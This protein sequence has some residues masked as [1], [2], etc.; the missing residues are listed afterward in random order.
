MALENISKPLAFL[1]ACLQCNVNLDDHPIAPNK[2]VP[3]TTFLD[4]IMDDS[5][6]RHWRLD[7]AACTFPGKGKIG[8]GNYPQV[9][10]E[11]EPPICDAEC[12]TTAIDLCNGPMAAADTTDPVRYKK[13]SVNDYCG[14]TW[15]L[16]KSEFNEFCYGPQ[17][18]VRT[19]M[20]R[21]STQLK[22]QINKKALENY[23][24]GADNYPNGT[25][26]LTGTQTVTVINNQGNIVPAG[27]AA[28]NA[29]YR[30][31]YYEGATKMIGGTTLG[32]YFDVQGLQG[33]G[34][35]LTGNT[36]PFVNRQFAYDSLLDAAVQDATGDT[37]A[38]Y[39]LVFP[40]GAF[41][42]YTWNANTGY[43]EESFEDFMKTTITIDGITYD[44]FVM[45]DKKC[46]EWTI[47]LGL[48]F[49]FLCWDEEDYCNNEGFKWLF[50]F[51]C[52]DFECDALSIC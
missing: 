16:N 37:T 4:M 38:S 1:N 39:G 19:E 32:T 33:G 30:K 9:Y 44:Y 43:R 10:I 6:M 40:E 13:L 50:K 34:Q 2:I 51:A 18:R 17:E 7:T 48:H 20:R 29:A 11:Y 14:V 5:N 42:I 15:R 23:I 45:Y 36:S 41:G 47:G 25:S 35:N 22:R 28:I 24:L 26:S 12:D 27:F 8:E 46:G 52:G 3:N 31:N 49:C 21:R